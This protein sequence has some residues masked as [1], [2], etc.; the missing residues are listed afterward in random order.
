MRIIA[1]AGHIDHGKS[2][3]VNALTGIDP[4]RLPEERA[5]GMTIELGFAWL[6]L[7]NGE[8]AGVVDVPG[9]ERFVRHMVAGVGS[10]DLAMLVVAADE[11]IMP[12]T[13]EHLAILDLL[14]VSHGVV[15]LTKS[16]LV[17]A[18]WLAL[19]TDEVR[20]VLA[21]TSLARSEIVP[22]SSVTGQGIG[23]LREALVRAL[24]QTPEPIDRGRPYLPIDRVFTRDGYGTVVTGTLLDGSFAVGQE[25][26][27]APVGRVGKIRGLQSYRHRLEKVGPGRRVAVNLAATAVDDLDRGM[28]LCLPG[29]VPA[30]SYFDARIRAVQQEGPTPRG[31]GNRESIV[32]HNML[33]SVHTGAVEVRGRVRLLDTEALK[34]GEE[35]WAQVKLERPIAALRGDRCILRIP[36]PAR[37]VAGGVIVDVNPPRHKRHARGVLQRMERRLVA[38]PEEQVTHI[39][40]QSAMT[41]GE[42]V[43]QLGLPLQEVELALTKLAHHGDVQALGGNGQREA[44]ASSDVEGIGAE[45]PARRDL[46][47]F[48]T[49]PA[50]L[51]QVRDAGLGVLKEFHQRH[52]MRR[53]M[54]GEALRESVKLDRRRWNELLQS[55]RAE[56]RVMVTGDLVRLPEHEVG[57]TA[58]QQRRAQAWL[59][60]LSEKPYAPPTGNEL[61]P[62]D[63][64]LLQALL[65]QGDPVRLAD[66]V[67]LRRTAFEEMRDAALAAISGDGQ[68]TVATI[69]DRFQTSRKFALALLEHLDDLHLTRRLG[70]VRVRG[71]GTLGNDILRR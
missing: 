54:P 4:D 22:C 5:R 27:I 13:R 15:A 47:G 66:G 37:T 51:N 23:S 36:T 12:Q 39:L 65:D 71:S 14:G 57:L 56:N 3:L 29:S 44:H 1:T 49:T 69:R 19:V 46:S 16:D 8:I 10:V 53:G 7:G 45:I 40:E 70:D 48:W 30:V 63:G 24:S 67:Y 41:I 28:V 62:L 61:A 42:L 9:H 21:G 11:A 2:S 17:D 60:H 43:A 52:P 64:E 31:D 58:D 33:V 26:E 35:A 55:W 68:V 34:A 50:W 38:S 18:D 6:D 59:N 20:S 32:T 25:V